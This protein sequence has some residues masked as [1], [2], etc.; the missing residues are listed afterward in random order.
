MNESAYPVAHTVVMAGVPLAHLVLRLVVGR[1][2]CNARGHQGHAGECE[3]AG[4]DELLGFH[5]GLSKQWHRGVRH[6]SG[7]IPQRSKPALG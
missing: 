1:G 7:A 3:D 6:T 2:G 4:E 5:G